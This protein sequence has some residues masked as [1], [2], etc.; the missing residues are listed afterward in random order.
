MMEDD[1]HRWTSRYS[2]HS[3]TLTVVPPS[4]TCKQEQNSDQQYSPASHDHVQGTREEGATDASLED[5]AAR[6]KREMQ[7]WQH[8]WQMAGRWLLL[9]AVHQEATPRRDLNGDEEYQAKND[10]RDSEEFRADWALQRSHT[11]HHVGSTQAPQ[12]RLEKRRSLRIRMQRGVSDGYVLALKTVAAMRRV[13]RDRDC[14]QSSV[15]S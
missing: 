15:V 6:R 9:G 3:N 14:S 8:D 13:G 12:R 11:T 10:C 7:E 5:E 4:P 1:E 2:I